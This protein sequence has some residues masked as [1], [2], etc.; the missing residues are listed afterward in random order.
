MRETRQ[1][2]RAHDRAAGKRGG[3]AQTVSV[4]RIVAVL[5]VIL[6]GAGGWYVWDQRGRR[7]P[8]RAGAPSWSHDSQRIVF[9][10]ELDNGKADLFLMDRDGS[11]VT[12]IVQTPNADEGAPSFSPDGTRIAYDSDEAGHANFEIFVVPL[13]GGNR[14]RLT[15]HPARDVAPA[16]S[17]DG[18]S[19]VF[20]S[21]RDSRPEFDVYRMNADGSG[22]E[23]LTKGATHWFPQY[24]PDGTRIAMHV[25]RDVHVLDVASKRLR[26]LTTDP[27]N[28]MYPTWSPDGRRIAF[29]SWRNAGR[30]EL[31]TMN[32][33]G[34]E[35]QMIVSMPR[36]SAI[37]P[38]WS[39]DGE[40]IA[41]VH[42]PEESVH[43][44]QSPDQQRLI[45]VFEVNS[46]RIMRLSR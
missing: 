17:P 32:A 39:P 21:D 7:P 26:R 6:A 33:D 37:D 42:V 25:W 30:T 24:S 19:I 12:P 43:G 5:A 46:G 41:F 9:Y 11:N 20:M 4:W 27:S 1:Q 14:R 44:Q 40:Y 10:A 45:Y 8:T 35:Q 38:R 3:P 28:G 13:S 2:R 23:R 36:G 31:F 18:K 29:M 16:W 22:V 34:S 15:N